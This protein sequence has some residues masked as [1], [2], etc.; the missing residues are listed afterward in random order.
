M[1]SLKGETPLRITEIP[2]IAHE[3]NEVP[4]KLVNDNQQVKSISYCNKC[5]TRASAGSYS[6]HEVKIP[7]RGRWED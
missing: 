4:K 5:H 1:H 6:E 7:G 3:H 2:S